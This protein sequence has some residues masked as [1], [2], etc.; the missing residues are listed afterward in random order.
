MIKTIHIILQA[1][2]LVLA[3]T[4][5]FVPAAAAA[6]IVAIALTALY[7]LT[8]IGAIVVA[9]DE[10]I[11]SI[12]AYMKQYVHANRSLAAADLLVDVVLAV[13]GLAITPV[14]PLIV[15]TPYIVAV[16]AFLIK[17]RNLLGFLS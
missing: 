13:V 3:V 16:E 4:S 14:A 11:P 17:K 15:I 9:I 12:Q 10:N 5:F 2:S 8:F 1:L 7:N 6:F